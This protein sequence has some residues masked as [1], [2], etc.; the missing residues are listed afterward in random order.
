MAESLTCALVRL[1]RRPPRPGGGATLSSLGLDDDASGAS[2]EKFGGSF[3]MEIVRR[4]GIRRGAEYGW[5]GTTG[6][7]GRT[8][9]MMRAGSR[10]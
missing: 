3:M 1:F 7:A 10:K 9:A 2:D 6:V 4:R 5:E 8:A